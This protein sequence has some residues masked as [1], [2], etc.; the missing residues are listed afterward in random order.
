ML[1]IL[2]KL[3]TLYTFRTNIERV[4]IEREEFAAFSKQSA[5]AGQKI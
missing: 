3:K 5:L 2:K 4:I 1:R